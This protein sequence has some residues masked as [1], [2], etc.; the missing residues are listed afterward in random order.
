MRWR[1]V[2]LNEWEG[3]IAYAAQEDVRAGLQ[4]WTELLNPSMHAHVLAVVVI[5]STR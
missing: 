3:L 5:C 1:W 4:L 2:K